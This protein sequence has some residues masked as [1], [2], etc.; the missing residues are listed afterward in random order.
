MANTNDIHGSLVTSMVRRQ[1]E[2]VVDYSK[3]VNVPSADTSAVVLATLQDFTNVY[4]VSP[5]AL[6][7]Q[8]ETSTREL[9]NELTKVVDVVYDPN[10]PQAQMARIALRE[11]NL[12]VTK[13]IE[14]ITSQFNM[15][16]D[17]KKHSLVK[18][19]IVYFD[20]ITS[21]SI[22]K[23]YTSS[24][25]FDARLVDDFNSFIYAVCDHYNFELP[26]RDI[27]TKA[28]ISKALARLFG[29]VNEIEDANTVIS[30]TYANYPQGADPKY[31]KSIRAN[32]HL[33]EVFV[34]LINNHH[35]KRYT[36]SQLAAFIAGKTNP[37]DKLALLA[38]VRNT[39]QTLGYT[40]G[41]FGYSNTAT[42]EIPTKAAFASRR[43]K[44][45]Q[46]LLRFG[47]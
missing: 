17:E 18:A 1:N 5:E 3:V 41:V 44:T 19:V 27:V 22:S 20:E 11:T 45:Y 47:L 2:P 8:D 40:T 13:V 28:D 10:S 14:E 7:T 31:D 9:L 12:V 35:N 30:Y 6:T 43:P 36:R 33:I 16:L 46:S 38:D 25:S 29:P 39:A 15:V 32:N 23:K 4:A 26:K 24:G 42:I 37:K 34:E 21:N